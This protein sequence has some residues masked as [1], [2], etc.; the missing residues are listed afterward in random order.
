MGPKP[1]LDLEK[2]HILTM[3]EENMAIKE[4]SLHIGST[5]TAMK[6]IQPDTQDLPSNQIPPHKSHFQLFN[7]SFS[8]WAVQRGFFFRAI[9]VSLLG[10]VFTFSS[11]L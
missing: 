1:I 5:M 10:E 4:K 9:G 3:T 7:P 6:K 11:R 8:C 2:A